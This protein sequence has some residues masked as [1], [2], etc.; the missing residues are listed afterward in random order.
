MTAPAA[1]RQS[2]G[3]R[4]R[5]S[6]RA[7]TIALKAMKDAGLSVDKLLINGA[8]IEIHCAGIE[9]T[10]HQENDEGLEKW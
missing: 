10:K 9:G 3:K 5:T 4:T 1:I 7:L 6:E 2:D 8:Q